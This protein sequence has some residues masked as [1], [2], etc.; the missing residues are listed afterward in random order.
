MGNHEAWGV[1]RF[2][3]ADFWTSLAA[4][5]ADVLAHALLALPLAARHSSTLLAVH[6][7]LPNVDS[8]ASIVTVEPGTPPW[9]DMTWG[10]WSEERRPVQVVL[11]RP[12]YGPDDFAA[13]SGRLGIRVLVRSHQPDAPT[14]LYQDR[15]LTLFTSSAYGGRR[16]VAVLASSRQVRS[17]RDLELYEI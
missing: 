12:L 13:R 1:A 5:E 8:L 7:A 15:C 14:Y 17:A 3:P 4:E 11:S 16:Q 9:R 10:D 2:R 6:A